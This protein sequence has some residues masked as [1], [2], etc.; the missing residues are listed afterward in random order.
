VCQLGLAST[1]SGVCLGR[2]NVSVAGNRTHSLWIINSLDVHAATLPFYTWFGCR[3]QES[4]ASSKD[5][6]II[7]KS[8]YVPADREL[9]SRSLALVENVKN[10]LIFT[11]FF[12]E[13]MLAFLSAIFVAC[14]V[15]ELIILS[16]SYYVL[17]A[18]ERI[19]AFCLLISGKANQAI[20]SFRFVSHYHLLRRN[21]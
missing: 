1:P 4:F 12:Q 7:I 15:V 5:I 19:W 3:V 14:D 17:S 8:S 16:V 6:L 11:E 10:S 2:F 13:C 18:F 9:G 20:Y 21:R